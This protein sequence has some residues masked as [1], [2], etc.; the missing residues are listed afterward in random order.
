M[1]RSEF[2][3]TL[4]GSLAAFR[5]PGAQNTAKSRVILTRSDGLKR[6]RHDIDS[7]RARGE[8]SRSLRRLTG[9]GSEAAA[10]SSLFSPHERIGI[11]LSCLPGRPLSSS[12][13]LVQ[14][15]CRGLRAS[16]IKA[17]NIIVW[18]RTRRELLNAGFNSNETTYQLRATDDFPS[19]GYS[20]RV[21]IS[22]SIGSCFS[23]IMEQVDALINVPVL[24]DHDLAGVSIGMKNFFGAIHNPNKYHDN[25]CDPYV[26]DLNN[27]ALIRK[28]LR[29][30]IC[31]ASRIQI[32]NG[33]AFSSNDTQEFGGLL[34]SRDPVALD[35]IG[36]RIIE[37]ERAARGLQSLLESGREPAYIR[38]AATL[39]LGFFDLNKIDLININSGRNED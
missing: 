38:R 24:K 21:E 34:V 30:V 27:H 32:N 37:G 23:T 25:N 11:K 10:W 9:A 19:G 5:L 3:R 36:W 12:T 20:N 13:G 28:K 17:G 18:E 31:D 22:G 8:L 6:L 39:G 15:I 33:P 29:L 1:R 14:A 7:I 26:A 2:T 16:G 35:R 4:A